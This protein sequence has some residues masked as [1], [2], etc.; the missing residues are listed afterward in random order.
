MSHA[1]WVR[2]RFV[3]MFCCHVRSYMRVSYV[4]LLNACV[5][6]ASKFLGAAAACAI[7]LSF[8]AGHRNRIGMA[9][10]MLRY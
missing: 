7:L 1:R 8:A 4:M 9:A 5:L 6:V 2:L 10:S 3:V